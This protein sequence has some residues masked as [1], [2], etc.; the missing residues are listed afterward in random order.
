MIRLL[1]AHEMTNHVLKISRLNSKRLLRK[2][3][4][5]VRGYFIL[6]HPVYIYISVLPIPAL[7]P[8]RL[9][10][11]ISVCVCIHTYI[12]TH[13]H[14]YI[15]D[16]TSHENKSQFLKQPGLR[17]DSSATFSSSW[18]VKIIVIVR[19]KLQYWFLPRCPFAGDRSCTRLYIIICSNVVYIII[20]ITAVIFASHL[21]SSSTYNSNHSIPLSCNDSW[22]V[23]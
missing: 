14:I 4:K 9:K 12:H 13:T 6:P 8:G 21:S 10:R 17:R 11:R 3:Q 23:I 20:I 16:S 18:H 2:L 19:A 7:N 5:N 22:Q 1:C 15:Y